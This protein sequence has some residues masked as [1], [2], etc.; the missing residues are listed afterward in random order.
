MGDYWRSE[1]GG[2]TIAQAYELYNQILPLYKQLHAYVRR[3][4][5]TK[6]SDHVDLTGRIPGNLLGGYG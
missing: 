3:I 5:N 4:M 6:H 1:Y 2:D